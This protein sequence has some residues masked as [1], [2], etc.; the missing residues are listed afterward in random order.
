MSS[1]IT[2]KL[3]VT[4]L[5]SGTFSTPSSGSFFDVTN[6]SLTVEVFGGLVMVGLIAVQTTTPGS[7][8]TAR[9][10]TSGTGASMQW[11]FL[12]DGATQGVSAQSFRGATTAETKEIELPPSAFQLVQTVPKGSVTYKFQIR[13]TNNASV[14]DVKMYVI[15]FP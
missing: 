14:F 12:R 2:P 10:T 5:S 9:N 15:A 3:T 6:L 13:A 1:L 8:I 4:T 11:Q 7:R